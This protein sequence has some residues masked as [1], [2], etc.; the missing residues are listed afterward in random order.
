MAVVGSVGSLGAPF[1]THSLDALALV[2]SQLAPRLSQL[3]SSGEPL[4]IWD[5]QSRVFAM[6]DFVSR[7]P[8]SASFVGVVVVVLFDVVGFFIGFVA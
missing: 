6:R 5:A 4:L 8:R 1:A 2:D 7:L 3:P